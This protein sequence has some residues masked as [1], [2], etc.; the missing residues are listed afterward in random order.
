MP[1]RI[2]DYALIGDCETA[3]LVA[4]N[5]SIDWLCWPRFDS[6]ACFAALLG[7]PEHGRWLLTSVSREPVVHR[8]YRAGTLILETEYETPQGAATVI[9]FMPPR[10]SA[11]D[12][13]RIVVGRRGRMAMRTELVLR[14]DYGSAVPWVTRIEHGATLQAIAGPDLALLRTPVPLHGEDF[15]TV[16]EFTVSEGEAVPFVLSYGPS[17]LPPPEPIDSLAALRETEAFWQEWSSRCQHTGPW[18]EAVLRSHITLKALTYRPTGGIVAAPTTSL[19]EQIGG[20]RNWDYRFCWLRD[21]TLTLLSLMDAGYQDEA[22]AWRDWLLR[23]V[24]G[25]PR[26]MQIMYGLA[27]ERRLTEFEA[28]WLPGYEASRPVRIGNAAYNQRQLDVYGEVMDALYQGRRSGLPAHEAGWALQR[29][30]VAHL[31]TIWDEPD[32]GIWEIRGGKRHFTH[33]K[34]MAWVAFDRMIR[35]A[36]EFGLEAP[37]TTGVSC[38]SGYTR[39]CAARG[40]IQSWEA[41]CSLLGLSILMPAFSCCLSSGFCRQPT[42][43]S[44]ERWRRS[45]DT[46][47]SMGPT[48]FATTQE[49]RRTDCRPAKAHFLR[50][51]SGWSTTSSYLAVTRRRAGCSSACLRC[52]T[53]SDFW[54]RSMT[55]LRADRSAISRKPSVIW[56]LRT[57]PEICRSVEF[58]RLSGPDRYPGPRPPLRGTRPAKEK[59][60]LWLRAIG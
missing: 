35:S 47:S 46:C 4:R 39:T 54:P 41:S 3:A 29:K 23:S 60:K 19:P 11:S 38:D 49:K 55:R 27:G 56:H 34:V 22:Q 10:G 52:V 28:S 44:K 16:G 21:A 14:F 12:L 8:G 26:Q 2:E 24:A 58:T 57:A 42:P 17:H 51:A 18:H 25:R 40:S 20:P 15:H 30:L 45:S 36:E 59:P 1:S 37:S 33:S 7:T 43:G 13:V 31:E 6:G 32:E 50:V 53:M 48:F 5:G 9:D